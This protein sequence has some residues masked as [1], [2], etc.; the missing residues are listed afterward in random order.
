MFFPSN[1]IEYLIGK[2]TTLE[3]GIVLYPYQSRKYFQLEQLYHS[4]YKELQGCLKIYSGNKVSYTNL[5][6]TP[7]VL[8]RKDWQ[9][10]YSYKE[11]LKEGYEAFLEPSDV[12][13]F[14]EGNPE[15]LFYE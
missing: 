9:G 1:D 3:K 7:A 4:R 8:R 10:R 12:I 15:H 2:S 6:E 11:V 14:V 5:C 13:E